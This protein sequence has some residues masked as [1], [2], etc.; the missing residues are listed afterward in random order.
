M[1]SMPRRPSSSNSAPAG[2]AAPLGQF[3]ERLLGELKTVVASQAIQEHPT[4][5]PARPVRSPRL[6]G[7]RTAI[8]ALVL[9]AAVAAGVV[10]AATV[11]HP[12]TS[13]AARYSLAADFLNHAAAAVRTQNAQAPKADQVF[14]FEQYQVL[15]FQP[16]SPLG[17]VVGPSNPSLQCLVMWEPSPLTD[18]TG[19]YFGKDRCTRGVPSLPTG[20][21]QVFSQATGH[22]YPAPDSL[23]KT[24]AALR[25]DLTTAAGHGAVYWGLPS[26][27][28]DQLVFDLTSRL[29]EAPI[30]GSLRAALYEMIAQLPG[31]SLVQN[32]TDAVG[33]HGTGILLHFQS[34]VH[35]PSTS[36]LIV[37]PGTYKFL[38]WTDIS[39]TQVVHTA[40]LS[41]G[42]VTLPRP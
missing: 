17:K 34:A 32:V 31:V 11:S 19:V 14:Y 36:M 37:A 1:N 5:S 8:T 22:W 27:P 40:D 41:S 35:G 12:A 42:L 18:A 6:R 33:R 4:Q 3:E 29:L 23:P 20:F 13:P 21:R 2:G 15:Y 16:G 26:M 25:A 38:G 9:S 30:S 10:V 39:T 7:R 24:P 28:S